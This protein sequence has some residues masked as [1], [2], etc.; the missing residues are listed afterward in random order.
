MHIELT[1]AKAVDHRVRP[2]PGAS[3]RLPLIDAGM[4]A[5]LA[6]SRI[7]QNDCDLPVKCQRRDRFP[8]SVGL[9][10]V[11]RATVRRT[12]RWHGLSSGS[13]KLRG[14]RVVS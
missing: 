3:S 9:Y 5:I 12:S 4:A 1:I 2:L 10:S 11:V 7:Y 6:V 13:S 14:L 8:R